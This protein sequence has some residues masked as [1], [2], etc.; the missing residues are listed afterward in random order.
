MTTQEF[1]I[2]ALRCRASMLTTARSLLHSDDEA[3]DVVQEV[4][5][6]LFAIRGRIDASSN[7]DALAQVAVKHAAIN[8]LRSAKR[9]SMVEFK[10]EMA[11]DVG[12][13]V[14]HTEMLASVLE[15]IDTLPSKQQIVLRLKHIESMEVEDIARVA[16]MSIDAVYQNLSRARRSILQKFIDQRR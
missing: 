2:F 9:H 10:P 3:E 1:E 11:V 7:P 5:L 13:E 8:V 4:L 12:E 16:Q 6:K 14:S 15:I